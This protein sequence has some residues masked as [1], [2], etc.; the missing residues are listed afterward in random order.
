LEKVPFRL[1]DDVEQKSP[2][3]L[4]KRQVLENEDEVLK[5]VSEELPSLLLGFF[6]QHSSLVVLLHREELVIRCLLKL[7]DVAFLG[8]YFR[9]LG[10]SV[11]RKILYGLNELR[12]HLRKVV[13]A[14]SLLPALIK[15]IPKLAIEGVF[16]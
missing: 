3:P 8:E 7:D 11:D 13:P 14:V 1:Q 4:R 9:N 6:Y 10:L 15:V 12:T 5:D 16:V 2:L